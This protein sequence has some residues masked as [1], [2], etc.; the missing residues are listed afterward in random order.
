M[1]W[2]IV[3]VLVAFGAGSSNA[4]APKTV[5]MPETAVICRVAETAKTAT[6]TATLAKG[7][8]ACEEV[9]L[10]RLFYLAKEI[11]PSYLSIA[12]G[13]IKNPKHSSIDVSWTINNWD[14]EK[15]RKVMPRKIYRELTG[16]MENL[17]SLPRE[18]LTSLIEYIKS[19]KKTPV[20]L[21][22][23]FYETD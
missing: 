9:D 13:Y 6:A 16:L 12:L 15:I 4:V 18:E 14:N 23:L 10:S 2:V 7:R 8:V 17:Q 5:D 19:N 3:L 22:K 11:R 20:K 21:A 1:P